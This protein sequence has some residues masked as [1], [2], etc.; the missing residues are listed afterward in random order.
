[1]FWQQ[2]LS[3]AFLSHSQCG[4]VHRLQL[5]P[6]PAQ[7]GGIRFVGHVTHNDVRFRILPHLKDFHCQLWIPNSPAH[8]RRIKDQRFNETIP[9]SAQHAIVVRLLNAACRIGTGIDHKDR[10]V[11]LK[12]AGN[13]AGQNLRSDRMHIGLRIHFDIRDHRFG[14][15][16]RR[17]PFCQIT[18]F[19]RQEKLHHL[20]HD[21][22]FDKAVDHQQ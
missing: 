6:Q 3:K 19:G 11:T 14:E 12:Q 15:Q 22:I 8:H 17:R 1:M 4:D 20:F 5:I 13:G 2:I 16:L 9:C 7:I 21:I 10:F 18:L